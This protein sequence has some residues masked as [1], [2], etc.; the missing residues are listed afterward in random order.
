V[1]PEFSRTYR[2]DTLGA[3]AREVSIDADEPER[4]ALARR[5][6]LL[7]ID[8]LSAKAALSRTGDT[9]IARGRVSAT[10][11]QACIATAD[12]VEETVEEDFS[13][14]F[15]PQPQS[16]GG[17]EEIELSEGELDVVFY[18]GAAIDLGEAV[19][20]TV[21]LALNP[22]PRSPRAEDALRAAGVQSEE[23]AR[24]QSSPFAALAA[25]KGKA[26]G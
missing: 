7:G 24:A 15:R 4:A 13:I 21:S 26:D 1:S 2:V 10:V 16:G 5:F 23:E 3:G 11:T 12:P 19:A 18:D 20:E 8:K 22:F 17:E 9:V 25:L 6:A 14:E